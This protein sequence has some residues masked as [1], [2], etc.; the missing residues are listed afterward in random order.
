MKLAEAIKHAVENEN[1][2]DV[3]DIY[4]AITGE[5]L[6]PPK[7]KLIIP[8]AEDLADMD[9]DSLRQTEG[10]LD[11]DIVGLDTPVE[12][13]AP[14]QE[15][16]KEVESTQKK[17]SSFIASAHKGDSPSFHGGEDEDKGSP[18]RKMPMDIPVQRVNKFDDDGR[19]CSRDKV[20]NNENLKKLYGEARDRPKRSD[21]DGAVDTSKR[22]DVICSLCDK[23]ETIALSLARGWSP[24]PKQNRYKCAKCCTRA[25]QA[26]ASREQRSM[27]SRRK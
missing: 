3:C 11:I 9:L 14:P 18:A 21:L 24:K 1:W 16:T 8:T 26:K 20:E 15:D 27:G 22:I 12:E 7:P 23:E 13:V 10:A 17:S 19:L 5:I 6:D 25:G 4:E 2:Q